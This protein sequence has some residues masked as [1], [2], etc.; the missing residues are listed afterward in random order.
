M[1]RLNHVLRHKYIDSIPPLH[2]SMDRLN[3]FTYLF[4][5]IS[6]CLYIPVWID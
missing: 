1:D 2:S 3:P 5:S 6:S 4:T